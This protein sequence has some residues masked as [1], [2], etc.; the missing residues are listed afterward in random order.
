MK[1]TLFAI[2]A[3]AFTFAAISC[4]KELEPKVSDNEVSQAAELV[5]KASIGTGTKVS[6][7]ETGK[8]SWETTDKIVIYA[9][10]GSTVM[11]NVELSPSTID[12]SSA[13]FKT[14]ELPATATTFAA[15]IK[16]SGISGLT[17][18]GGALG[19]AT[20]SNFGTKGVP[21]MSCAIC[22]PSDLT[23]AFHNFSCLVKVSTTRSD[24]AYIALQGLNGEKIGQTGFI[25][26]TG[27]YTKVADNASY[28]TLSAAIAGAPGTY[29]ICLPPGVEFTKGFKVFLAGSTMNT[30]ATF[31]Y[32]LPVTTAAN[33]MLNF[34]DFAAASKD[35][36]K[37][38]YFK[39]MI[40]SKGYNPD[41]Y[42]RVKFNISPYSYFNATDSEGWKLKSA[43]MTG[44]YNEYY[45]K[46]CSTQV[47]DKSE[48][49]NGTLLVQLPGSKYRPDG[50]QTIGYTATGTRSGEV[51]DAIVEVNDAWWGNFTYRGFNLYYAVPGMSYAEMCEIPTNFAIFVPKKSVSSSSVVGI[52]RDAGYDPDKYDQLYVKVFQKSFWNSSDNSNFG[53][54]NSYWGD[55]MNSEKYYKD[56]LPQTVRQSRDGNTVKFHATNVF[57]KEDIPVG[58]IIVSKAGN[59]NYRPD[60]WVA[61]DQKNS[62]RP[63]V[64]KDTKVKVVDDAWWGSLNYRAF[65]LAVNTY[66]NGTYFTNAEQETVRAS[67]AIFVP[68]D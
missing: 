47:F 61:M 57:T 18:N 22:T 58:S 35:K 5:F 30:L 39:L 50:W 66:A 12:G 25:S 19:F 14:S 44:V 1:K 52:L 56:L 2:L 63:G 11:G 68:R 65:N 59:F 54:L 10:S 23:L 60:G 16:G 41:D 28:P 6:A 21:T 17:T 29:Y 46:F 48:L 3:A 37:D 24:V 55:A 9:I 45:P 27:A 7:G 53:K 13:T 20:E 4:Q 43:A 34:G 42:Y 40:Q 33:K 38:K 31:D 26:A 49:P 36:I 15:Y 62:S 8:L 32:T 64:V 51:A 67:F